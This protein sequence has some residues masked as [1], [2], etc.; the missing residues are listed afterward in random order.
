MKTPLKRAA[1]LLCL[2]ITASSPAYAGFMEGEEAFL[3]G[4]NAKALTEWRKGAEEGDPQSE[5]SLAR[6]Y[7]WGR[8]V[9]RDQAQ[10]VTWYRKAADHGYAVA[11]R[12][13]GKLH[14][15]GNGVPRSCEEAMKW[16][17]KAADQND[18]PAQSNIGTLYQDGCG[19][20]RDAKEAYQW[21]LKA[22]DQGYVRAL[23]AIGGFYYLGQAVSQDYVRA[24]M[25]NSLAELAGDKHA[26]HNRSLLE[27]LMAPEQI[28]EAHR[29][30][31]DWLATHSLMV[32]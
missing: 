15:E 30:V 8:G 19:V 13:M 32:N 18:A 24:Y 11:Q 10:A 6:M 26:E 4:D 7:D 31:V 25:Y 20:P 5:F 28:E 23:R 22:A 17:R 12:E 14:H 27:P 2:L 3:A 21:F 29:L 16:Y 1:L 9:E